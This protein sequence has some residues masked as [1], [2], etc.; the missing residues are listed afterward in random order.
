MDA[1]VEPGMIDQVRRFNRAVTQR[2][3]ALNDAYLSR[4]RPLGQARLLWEIGARGDDVRALR[5]RLD[6][7]SGYLSRMLRALENDGL[8]AVERSGADGRVRRARLTDHGLRER[9]VL[10]RRSDDAAGSIL[11]P[12]SQR[13]RARLVT[14]MAEVERL[15]VAS[16]VRIEVCD[17]RKADARSC[18]RAYFAELAS[19]FDGGFDPDRGIPAGERELTPPAGLFLLVTVRGE[20]VGCAGLKLPRDAP[21]EIKRMWLAPAVRGLGLGHRLLAELER[22]ATANRARTLRLETNRA[23]A[24]AIGLYRAAGYQEVAAY[25]DEPYAHHWFEKSLP[26]AN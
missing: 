13:Q 17:P 26:P 3:G 9:A 19:R 1:N 12:L 5:S 4:D 6:L 11:E 10:D 23:L 15:L 24:E 16:A 21:A 25:N 7:D 14:A 2:V 20:P 22:H 8:V 18:L